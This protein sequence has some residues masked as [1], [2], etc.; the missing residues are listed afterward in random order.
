MV[1]LFLAQLASYKA[2]PWCAP[3]SEWVMTR[4]GQEAFS[5]CIYANMMV[6]GRLP[7]VQLNQFL[8]CVECVNGDIKMLHAMVD[9]IHP[10]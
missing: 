4:H 9:H 8:S 10:S 1:P 7:Q 5:Q 2:D 3:V 6:A